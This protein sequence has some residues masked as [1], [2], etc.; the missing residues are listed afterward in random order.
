MSEQEHKNTWNV[1]TRL[2]LFGTIAVILLLV[3]L[4]ATLL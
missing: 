2:V 4:A 1:F 3:I